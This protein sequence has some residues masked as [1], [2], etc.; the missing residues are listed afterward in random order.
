MVDTC[1][2][3]TRG[4]SA[5]KAI[6]EVEVHVATPV[7]GRDNHRPAKCQRVDAALE[8]GRASAG[9]DRDI[10][11]A[12]IGQF[13]NRFIEVDVQAYC[14]VCA[15]GGGCGLASVV[16][17]HG[18]YRARSDLPKEHRDQQANDALAGHEDRFSEPRVGV[19]HQRDRRL[20]VRD[21]DSYVG[22]DPFGHLDRSVGWHHVFGLMRVVHKNEVVH[23]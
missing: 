5:M 4:A 7:P 21:E 22:W 8:S 19:E 18:H 16:E 17:I 13:E 15:C 10:H 2:L 11:S 3:T 12:P 20:E 23:G 6:T 14:V 9:L 1:E